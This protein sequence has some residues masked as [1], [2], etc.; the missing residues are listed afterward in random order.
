MNRVVGSFLFM[1]TDM[2]AGLSCVVEIVHTITKI[3]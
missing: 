1:H 2:V 3:C